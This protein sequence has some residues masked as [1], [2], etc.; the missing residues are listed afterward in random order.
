VT[1]ALLDNVEVLR[2]PISGEGLRALTAMELANLQKEVLS[3]LW[4]HADA[5]QLIAPLSGA[6]TTP[7]SRIVYRVEEEIACLLPQLAI[8]PASMAAA[9]APLREEKRRVQA[10]YDEYGWCKNAAGL[11]NDTADF[12]DIRNVA[13][14]YQSRAQ[15]RIG[16][17]LGS[18]K[19][20]LD[21]ASGAIPHPEY[22]D[23]GRSYKR[24][25]CVDLS[26]RALREARHKLGDRGIYVM[27][28]VTRLPLAA[29]SVDGIVSLHTIYHLPPDEQLKAVAELRRVGKPSAPIVIVYTWRT[30]PLMN[31]FSHLRGIVRWAKHPFGHAAVAGPCLVTEATATPP[32]FYH[33]QDYAWYQREV[34]SRY[35]VKLRV[36]CAVS[37]EFQRRFFSENASGRALARAVRGLE[38]AFP[39]FCGRFGQYP[40]FILGKEKS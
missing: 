32:L 36:W 34:L 15:G 17:H 30:S 23:F 22:L 7:Q 39:W 10:F 2:C 29:A 28:D 12:T 26:L 6:L 25:I 11:F 3:G 1:S 40:M 8:R 4:R 27:G 14:A 20:L 16:R 9:E 19:F 13:R 31:F 5:T 18:G 24:R 38:T 21:A 35:R 33:P 37:T